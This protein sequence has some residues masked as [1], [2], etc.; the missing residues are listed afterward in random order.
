MPAE[1]GLAVVRLIITE[2]LAERAREFGAHLIARLEELKQRYEVIGD[3][4]GRGLLI[5]ASLS[6]TAGQNGPRMTS[7]SA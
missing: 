1:V 7:C 2:R 3:V 4:R 6:R 5:G